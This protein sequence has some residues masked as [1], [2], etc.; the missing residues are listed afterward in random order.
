MFVADWQ[1]FQGKTPMKLCYPTPNPSPQKGG[2][3]RLKPHHRWS[4]E[5]TPILLNSLEIKTLRSQGVKGGNRGL[6][7]VLHVLRRSKT[8]RSQGVKGGNRGPSPCAPCAPLEIKTLRSQGVKGGNRGLLHVLHVLRRSKNSKES[9]SK[10]KESGPKGK[11]RTSPSLGRAGEGLSPSPTGEGW[12]EAV[13]LPREGWGGSAAGRKMVN[14]V[15]M[16]AL[17]PY[18]LSFIFQ[19]SSLHLST[20]NKKLYLC[21]RITNQSETYMDDIKQISQRLKGLREIFDIP[22]EK[23]AE[24][25]ETTVEH[26]QRIEN[27]EC[28]PGVYLLSRISKQYGIALDV[29]LYGEEPR[30]NGYFVTRRG[31]GLEVD[32][33]N[34]YKYKSLASGFKGRVME[35][36][37][38]EI[39]PLPDGKNHAKNV[40]DGQEFII[41]FDGVL[42]VTIEDKVI[43]LRLG[44]SIYFDTTRPHCMRALEN[45]PV[46]FLTVI[47]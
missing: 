47:I 9:R 8:L 31:N 37:F 44:D 39:E 30:M 17:E 36:F 35:P 18:F 32:R 22:L 38:T 14:N 34:D 40:H 21:T 11:S 2:E 42:E 13:S 15:G 45:K 25:C 27:G 23:M 4:R 29:L 1:I 43:V 28:D 19:F 7:H 33:H 24:V 3:G 10:R 6:L 41:V 20:L 26:Y 5:K 46:K 12:G 16:L